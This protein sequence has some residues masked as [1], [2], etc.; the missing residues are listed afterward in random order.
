MNF[1]STSLWSAIATVVK[2]AS[3]LVVNK[4]IAVYIGPSG[5]ALI[6][7]FQNFLS[8]VTTLGNGAINS[9]VTKYVAEYNE[10]APRKRDLYISAAIKITLFVSVVL[11]VI[12]IVGSKLISNMLFQQVE[13]HIVFKILGVTLWMTSLNT[14]LISIING[15]KKI[16]L[17]II[18]N[19]LGSLLSLV[20]T[21]LLT[22]KY[23]LWG[24]L[25]TIILVQ[26]L[27]LFVSIPI[28]L[29]KVHIQFQWQK[30]VSN[31]YYKKLFSFSAMAIVSVVCVSVTQIA[32]RNHLINEFSLQE[33][34]Y[35]QSMWMISSMY[36]M[37]ITTALSTYY[38]PKL[39]EL[40]NKNGI[41]K[42]IIA[43]YKVIIPFVILSASI[44]YFSRDYIIALLFTNDFYSMRDLFFYQLLGDFFKM[45]SWVLAYL[46]LAKKMTKLFIFTEIVSSLLFYVLTVVFTLEKGLVGVVYAH[47]INYFIYAVLMFIIIGKWLKEKS[48]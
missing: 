15:L 34:G 20:F 8:V 5:I 3:G 41:K 29:K 30:I 25:L 32:I 43:G 36:L 42:E 2:L 23:E 14:I 18:V 22:L 35:W 1:L 28:M 21:V 24:A 33:A 44:I 16:K 13:F 26:A 27:L 47:A 19:I 6:G 45:C 11:G 37:I 17:Y 40:K 9:G 10:I 7:Q 39:S 12:L 38:L 48:K 31:D 4:I 46:M